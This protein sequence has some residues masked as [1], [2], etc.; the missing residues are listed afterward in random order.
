MTHSS[1]FSISKQA[2]A[3]RMIAFIWPGLCFNAAIASF[4]A[5]LLFP[6]KVEIKSFDL[7]FKKIIKQSSKYYYYILPFAFFLPLINANLLFP[8]LKITQS[9]TLIIVVK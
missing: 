6:R 7:A 3:A 1:Y 2:I 9:Q 5:V 4:R 8:R